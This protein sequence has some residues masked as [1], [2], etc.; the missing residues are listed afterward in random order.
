MHLFKGSYSRFLEQRESRAKEAEQ[1][2]LRLD[3]Q[4]AKLEACR[5][6]AAQLD[7]THAAVAPPS[8]SNPGPQIYFLCLAD[9]AK[10]LT[11]SSRRFAG[12]HRPVRSQGVEGHDCEEQAEG[13]GQVRRYKPSTLPLGPPFAARAVVPGA[14]SPTGAVGRETSL[15]PRA[16]MCVSVSPLSFR[17]NNARES[18]G[19]VA[20]SAQ[21]DAPGDA[22]RVVL[23]LPKPLP[24]AKECL[25]LDDATFGAQQLPPLVASCPP[26]APLHR[27]VFASLRKDF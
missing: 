24:G 27:R 11:L 25:T 8:P 7:S 13:P 4:A 12:V 22:T 2:R 6:V 18:M 14:W 20:P 9:G 21:G 10:V 17:I 3:E 1:A 26:P 5:R 16:P 15:K 19:T 23:K